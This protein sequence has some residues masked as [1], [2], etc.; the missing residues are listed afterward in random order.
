MLM[1]AQQLLALRALLEVSV[2]GGLQR[3]LCVLQGRMI[4]TIQPKQI[5][6]SALAGI[7]AQVVPHLV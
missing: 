6:C 2:R 1:A 4:M 3:K 7:I 5:V